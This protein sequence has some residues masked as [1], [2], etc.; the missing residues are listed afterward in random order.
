MEN[1]W[2]DLQHRGYTAYLRETTDTDACRQWLGRILGANDSEEK[3]DTV[4]L[5]CRVITDWVEQIEK[6]LPFV[7]K[8]VRESRQFILRQGQTVPVEKVKRVSRASVEH[9]SRHSELITKVPEPGGDLR[10]DKLHMTENVGTFAVYENRFL[11]M[12]IFSGV[13]IIRKNKILNIHNIL[14]LSYILT[15]IRKKCNIKKE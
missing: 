2:L 12:K 3:I 10:P 6:A 4:F 11:Y 5:D 13:F 9:L 7:E 14:L 1:N 15:H 8:A